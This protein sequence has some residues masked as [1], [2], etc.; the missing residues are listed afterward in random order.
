MFVLPSERLLQYYKNSVQQEPGLNEEVFQL[1]REEAE[2]RKVP[3]FG[4]LWGIML[5]EMSIQEDLQLKSQ[6]GVMKL[7]GLVDMGDEDASIRKLQ[8]G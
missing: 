3:Q 2:K 6:N 5:D 7:V 8:T 1:M 4:K